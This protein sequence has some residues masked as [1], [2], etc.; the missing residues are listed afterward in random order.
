MLCFPVELKMDNDYY[1]LICSGNSSHSNAEVGPSQYYSPFEQTNHGELSWIRMPAAIHS[2]KVYSLLIYLHLFFISLIY[3]WPNLIHPLT[4][5]LPLYTSKTYTGARYQPYRN[6]WLFLVHV[7]LNT[8]P[9]NSNL[10]CPFP[11]LV[12]K[13]I[14]WMAETQLSIT[15]DTME[16]KNLGSRFS[17]VRQ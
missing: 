14:Q 6:A 7:M 9:P 13:K 5:L 12:V 4:P 15:K 16:S 11:D 8:L 1:C 2:I 17:V 3:F 10:T